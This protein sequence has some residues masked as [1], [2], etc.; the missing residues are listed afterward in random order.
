M[1]IRLLVDLYTVHVARVEN[2]ENVKKGQVV[3]VL[4]WYAYLS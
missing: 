4:Y 3:F 2:K 1:V